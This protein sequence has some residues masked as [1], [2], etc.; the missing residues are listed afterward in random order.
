MPVPARYDHA[1][2]RAMLKQGKSAKAIATHFGCSVSVVR[3][4]EAEIIGEMNREQAAPQEP[5]TWARERRD[6]LDAHLMLNQTIEHLGWDVKHWKKRHDELM[7]TNERLH[8]YNK[9]LKA[10]IAAMKKEHK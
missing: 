7:A 5:A 3:R 9:K 8:L 1:A 4:C 10:E 6:L 2:I